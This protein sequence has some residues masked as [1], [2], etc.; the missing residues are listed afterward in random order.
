M[1]KLYTLLTISTLLF[2]CNSKTLAQAGVGATYIGDYSK[3][4]GHDAE[5]RDLERGNWA[6]RLN[7]LKGGKYTFVLTMKD[8]STREV[9]SKLYADSLANKSYVVDGQQKVYCDETRA[10]IRRENGSDVAGIATDSCWLFKIVSGKINAYSFLS[11]NA[12]PFSIAALQTQNGPIQ[13]FNGY[14]LEQMINTDQKAM[15]AF[16]K[17]DYIKAI[18]KFNA[19]NK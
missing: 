17:R 8:N 12:G 13:N 5:A 9:K 3:M 1:L 6:Y 10:I 14:T 7:N 11:E 16:S 4:S 18:E 15:K 19:N 2:I